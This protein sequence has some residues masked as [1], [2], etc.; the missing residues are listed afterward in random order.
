[1][2]ADGG[3]QGARGLP[4]APPNNGVEQTR[5]GRSSRRTRVRPAWALAW[6]WES[7]G[8][9]VA[10]I[11]AKRKVPTVRWGLEEAWSESVG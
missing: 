7:P 1:M 10:G 11:Q 9:Q 4:G 2:R 3:P 5:F 6:G 8:E